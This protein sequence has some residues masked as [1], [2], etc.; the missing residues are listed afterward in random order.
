M[1]ESDLEVVKSRTEKT[2]EINN[3]FKSEGITGI[4]VSD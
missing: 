1:A 2:I 4:K 3:P